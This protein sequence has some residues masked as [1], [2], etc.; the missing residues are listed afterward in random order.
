MLVVSV[1]F[2]QKKLIL[3]LFSISKIDLLFLILEKLILAV[4]LFKKNT[5]KLT[6]ASSSFS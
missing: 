2:F 4:S 6:L 1:Y 5:Q 3:A